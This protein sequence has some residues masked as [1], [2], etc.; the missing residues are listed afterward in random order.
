MAIDSATVSK[1]S[2]Q[3]AKFL[4]EKALDLAEIES[5]TSLEVTDCPTKERY[6]N[7]HLSAI[8]L[9][10]ELC[11][12]GI[13]IHFMYP[14]AKVFAARKFNV[15]A[16]KIQERDAIEF[17]KEH[18]N[19]LAGHLRA[20][21]EVVGIPVGHS[22]PF[23]VQGYNEVFFDK[24]IKSSFSGT[25]R[26]GNDDISMVYSYDLTVLSSEAE[27]KLKNLGQN[28]EKTQRGAFEVL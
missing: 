15:A 21:L 5:E 13:K 10:S 23:A 7:Q 4:R 1:G 3:F 17:L 6:Y 28:I 8:L 2:I 16:D 11:R 22:L 14:M 18:V 20:G 26:V 25:F 27:D 12:I 9:F 24:D 19:I